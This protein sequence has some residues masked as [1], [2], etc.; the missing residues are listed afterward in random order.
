MEVWNAVLIGLSPMFY[1]ARLRSKAGCNE[2]KHSPE[3]LPG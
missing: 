1:P 3:L 2:G